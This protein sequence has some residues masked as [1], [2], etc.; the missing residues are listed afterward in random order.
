M[1]AFK[2]HIIVVLGLLT[3]CAPPKPAPEA[4]INET[5][6]V[7]EREEKTATISSWEISGA[8]AANNQKKAWSASL[9]WR[10]QG[11]NRYQIRL[12]GP[13]GG[14]T[15]I[16]EKEGGMITYKDGPKTASSNSA[17]ELLYQQTGIRLPV[18]NLYYW[19]RG[20]PA[21]GAVQSTK[22]DQYNH[23]TQ[24]KQAGYTIDY[25]RYTSLKNIDLPSKIR[26]KGHGV[27]IKLII[28]RWS[29]A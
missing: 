5:M 19:V 8:M 21:P 3:A 15:V 24:L 7:V 9:N 4:P 29:V 6:P 17:D 2:R 20:L 1:N 14:G 18:T 12:F 25:A 10:Q 23:L 28:K 11:M 22:Y 13:L 16:I 26:L 27:M